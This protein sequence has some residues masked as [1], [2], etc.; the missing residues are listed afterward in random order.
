MRP[1]GFN[2]QELI[3]SLQGTCNSIDDHLPD[4]MDWSDLT[5]QDHT[6]IDLQIFLCETC[7]WWCE[8]SEAAD[9]DEQICQ[10]C[11]EE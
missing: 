1:S 4:G 3:D 6:N 9:C 7:G 2:V 11:K 8:I 10:D 5:S